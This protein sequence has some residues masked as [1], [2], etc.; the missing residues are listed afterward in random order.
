MLAF[1]IFR[2]DMLNRIKEISKKYEVLAPEVPVF[3]NDY[4]SQ[5]TLDKYSAEIDYAYNLLAD[6]KSKQIFK[7]I[8]EYRLTGNPEPL[9]AAETV[10]EEVFENI[11]HEI[12]HSL[13]GLCVYQ[14]YL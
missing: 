3:G 14:I 1:A 13:F 4:F 10:R 6:E 12:L 9:F 2:D 5:E 7:K 8:L 11:I